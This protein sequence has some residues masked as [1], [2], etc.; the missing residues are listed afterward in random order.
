MD[1][2]TY[3]IKPYLGSSLAQLIDVPESYKNL[4]LSKWLRSLRFGN[5][6]FQIIDADVYF[7][8]YSQYITLILN[9][10][11]TVVRLAVLTDDP[12]VVLGFSVSEKNKIH[13]VH[14]HKDHRRLG[15]GSDLLPPNV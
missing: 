8:T 4:V 5:D 3:T 13:F 12:D 11:L 14:V 7:K 9:R 15:I 2:N 10:P 6:Y 1:K